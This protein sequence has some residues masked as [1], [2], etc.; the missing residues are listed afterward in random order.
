MKS[1]QSSIN[2]NYTCVNSKSFRVVVLMVEQSHHS[3]SRCHVGICGLS[4]ILGEAE[5]GSEA[6]IKPLSASISLFCLNH[7]FFLLLCRRPWVTSSSSTTATPN[8]DVCPLYDACI[9]L[10]AALGIANT[11]PSTKKHILEHNAPK[12]VLYPWV[13]AFSS[14]PGKS[15]WT[16]KLFIQRWSL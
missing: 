15:L 12:L 5:D 14:Q 6:S 3:G 7:S 9:D 11:H 16:I 8:M 2:E 4:N 13:S 1:Q 10:G